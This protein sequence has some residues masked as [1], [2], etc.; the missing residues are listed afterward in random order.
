VYCLLEADMGSD[1]YVTYVYRVTNGVLEKV[2]EVYAAIDAANINPHEIKMESWVF[3]LGTYGGVKNYHFDENGKFITEDSEY[4][5][6]RNEFVLTTTTDLPV[7]IDDAE[8]VLLAGSHIILSATD[9]ESYV[10]FTIQETGQSGM[11][12]VTKEEGNYYFTIH[13]MNESDCFE[14]LPYAG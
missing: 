1:D 14:I 2:N 4:I 13:G 8:S 6:Q 10:K 7:V 9:G 5:L 3:L 11:L 12:E